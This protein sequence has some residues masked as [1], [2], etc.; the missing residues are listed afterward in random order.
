MGII[1]KFQTLLQNRPNIHEYNSTMEYCADLIS[2]AV[3][4]ENHIINLQSEYLT[5]CANVIKTIGD[6]EWKKIKNSSTVQTLYYEGTFDQVKLK[7][8]KLAEALIEE[9]KTSVFNINTLIAHR[10]K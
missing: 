4:L 7:E 2:E 6:E 8:L 5:H 1:E 3:F 9:Y 10:L